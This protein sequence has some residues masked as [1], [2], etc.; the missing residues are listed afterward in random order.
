[1][2]TSGSIGVRRRTFAATTIG[3]AIL[4]G[5]GV[6]LLVSA[7]DVPALIRVM[8]VLLMLIVAQFAVHL[9]I[10]GVAGLDRGVEWDNNGITNRANMVWPLTPQRIPWSDI[11]AIEEANVARRGVAVP[12]V[13]LGRTERRPVWVFAWLLKSPEDDVKHYVTTTLREAHARATA[14]QPR[15]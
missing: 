4:A 8:A 2:V 11:T 13:L 12:Y 10:I 5:V 3:V 15:Q 1:M 14:E 9:A 7:K 6:W